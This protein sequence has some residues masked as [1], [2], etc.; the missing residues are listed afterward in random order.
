MKLK[1]EK[2]F[3]DRDIDLFINNV[4]Q[5]YKKFPLDKYHFDLSDV[6]Y[7]A[8]Q[9]LLVLSALFKSFIDANIDFNVQFYNNEI[10]TN[11]IPDRV[12]KVIIQFWEVW[13]VHEIVPKYTYGKYFGLD[14]NLIKRF[15]EELGYFPKLSEIYN[16]H[17][18]TP[19]IYLNYIRNYNEIDIKRLIKPIYKLNSAII[20]L[21]KVNNCQHPFTSDALSSIITEELYLNFLDHS[22]PSSFKG[23]S[24]NA[25]MSISFQAKIDEEKISPEDIQKRAKLNFQSE[26]IDESVNF[27]YDSKSKNF[28][29]IPYIQFSF[30][31]FGQGIAE[32]L[33]EHFNSQNEVGDVSNLDSDILCFAFNHNSSRH[34]LFHSKSSFEK[35]IPRG[36][37]DILT[38]VSRYKGLLIARSNFGKIIFDFSIEANQNNFNKACTYFGNNNLYFPGTL[39]S[40]YIPAI[41]D[42]SKLNISSIKPETIFSKIKPDNKKYVN[43]NSIAEKIKKNKETFYNNLLRD[44]KNEIS[45][46]HNHSLVF[47]SF[48]GCELE[49]GVIKKVMYF[50]VSDYNINHQNNVIILNTPSTD[51]IKEI[52]SEI[53]MLSSAIKN[54]KLHPLPIIDFDDNSEDISITWLGIY[55]DHDKKKLNDLLYEDYTIAKSEFLDP[56]NISGHLNEFD[57]YGNLISNFPI[58]ND[59]INFYKKESEFIVSKQIEDLLIK[60]NCLKKDNNTSLY[61]CNGNYYQKEYIELTNLVNDKNDC[62]I[63]SK[64]LFQKIEKIVDKKEEYNFIGISATSQKILK[65]LE[66]QNLIT[67]K[68]YPSLDNFHTIENDVNK[69]TI[70]SKK[71]YILLCDVISTGAQSIT[72]NE[73]LRELNTKIEYIAVIVSILSPEY[74]ATK[75]ILSDFENRIIYLYQ[76]PIKKFKRDTIKSEILTKNIIRINPHTNIPI[77]ISINETNY[78]ESIIFQSTISYDDKNNKIGINNKFLDSVKSKAINVGFLK[79][80]SVI[81]PYFFNTDIILSEI[82]KEILQIIFN[83]INKTHL[84][85]EKIQVYYPRKSGIKSFNFNLLKD[86]LAN[87]AI[88]II[89]LERI[90]TPEGWRF[91]HNI[92]YLSTKINNNI[93]FI[94]DDGSCSGDSLIQMIDEI[95]FYNAKEILLLSF[96][97]RVNDH[98]REFFSRISNIRVK[99]DD[100]IPI[101][102][103]FACHLHIPTYYIDENPN[104]KEIGWLNEIIR[105]PNT[106][107]TI[108]NI[109]D[110]VL[111]E[112]TPK[113]EALFTDYKYLP[114]NE[115]DQIPKKELLLVR[116]EL[117][118]VIGYR[119][120]KESFTFFDYFIKKYGKLIKSNDRYKEIELLC[121]TFIFEPYLFDKIK[122][123]LPDVIEKVEDFVRV[124]IFSDQKIYDKLTYKWNKIDIIHLF[125]I[126]FK[127]EKLINELNEEMFKKLL[128]FTD[129]KE[130]ALNYALYKLLNYFA[131]NDTQLKEKKFDTPIKELLLKL[132]TGT[133]ASSKEIRKFYNFIST[134]PSRED[135][136]FQLGVLVD[137]YNKQKEPEYHIGKKSFDHNVSHILALI[138]DGINSIEEGNLLDNEKIQTIRSRW[139]ELLNFINPILS[140]SSSFYNFLVPYPYFELVNMIESG[141]NSLRKMV[142]FNEDVLFVLNESYNDVDKLKLVEKNIVKIQLD[143]KIE[144]T[145]NK[146]VTNRFTNLN[147]LLEK[148]TNDIQ[149]IPKKLEIKNKSLINPDVKIFIPELYSEIIITKELITNLKNHAKKE[150]DSKILIEYAK[151]NESAFQIKIINEIADLDFINSNGEGL[152]CLNLLSNFNIFDFNYKSLKENSNFIQ[153]LTFNIQENGYK[154]N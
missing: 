89:E 71:K 50:L 36:L 86:V 148:I 51:L 65:S 97:G 39:I 101:S 144:S 106:P 150:I 154:K 119:F 145:F 84:K 48:K 64:L 110:L 88:E 67:S 62:E 59:I 40:L 118:K 37:F 8:N 90:G 107:H 33:R 129:T 133:S 1:L 136:N 94:L 128:N 63:V 75:L 134:L 56:A 47:I 104:T 32:T 10:S 2:K 79:F 127:N 7:I 16:R 111:A 140:F 95:S 152:K 83:K 53:L 54:Y 23:F 69:E 143:L 137:N 14:G 12:K 49:R 61:L 114:K 72:L 122:N 138:R 120:Y 52:A 4:Y 45:D 100:S 41:E 113:S 121:A 98:K 44:I 82:K 81:H 112:I 57:S 38:V 105:L 85:Y 123:V 9:E 147:F 93:C 11:E 43:I 3:A 87:H 19:F 42:F 108:K 102:I 135:L 92:D 60:H 74:D 28:K 55:N 117:G 130:S 139:F 142:G 124:L 17:G 146:L 31:D 153:I 78:K 109:A 76:Y 27:F 15:Q 80:N 99:N 30:L 126:V 25:F 141:D 24:D 46:S 73:K 21:L 77:N 91:P 103:Y 22:L 66:S 34:P 70:N 5:N 13:K 115:F 125:F 151:P 96:V 35:F 20:D 68:D 18:I 26:C 132:K 29:N 149:K 131:I 58:R 6:E 116:E